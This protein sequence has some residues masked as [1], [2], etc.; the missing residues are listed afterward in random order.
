MEWKPRKLTHEQLEERR[1]EAGRLLKEGRL[2]Q[3]QIAK[4][5]GVSRMAVSQWA[6]CYRRG[7][8]RRL[9]RRVAAGRPPKLTPTQKRE[10]KRQLKKG[11]L[12]AGFLTDRW[13]LV[14]AAVL[15]ERE[16]GVRY[17][18]NYLP[19]LL[20]SLGF[21]LQTPQPTAAERDEELIRAWLRKDWPRIKKSAAARRH[22]C[23]LR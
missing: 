15:I 18:P 17:H 6:K 4:Q 23:L 10:L 9:Q 14:R 1:L 11:A 20:R 2:S 13:T 16:F 22:D 5:L 7:G 12:A 19:R 21:T 8:I 3:S